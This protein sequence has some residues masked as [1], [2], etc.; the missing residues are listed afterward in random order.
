MAFPKGHKPN[1]AA[2]PGLLPQRVL[3]RI[4]RQILKTMEATRLIR[5][6]APIQIHKVIDDAGEWDR[7][8]V[9]KEDAIGDVIRPI[10]HRSIIVNRSVQSTIRSAE[11][12]FEAGRVLIIQKA[13][14]PRAWKGIGKTSE[15]C[16]Y[17]CHPS[18]S[19]H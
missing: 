12:L 2:I 4:A 9:I 1:S 13:K 18:R 19:F 8:T 10:R 5:P 7:N 14:Q 11:G 17:S 3:D 15:D 16:L 6:S